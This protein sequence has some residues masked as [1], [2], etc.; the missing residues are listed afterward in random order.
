MVRKIVCFFAI[1]ALASPSFAGDLRDS[2]RKVVEEGAQQPTPASG[3]R[4]LWPGIALLAGGAAVALYG[5]S[6]T[7]GAE[8]TF[9]SD[10]FGTRGNIGIEEK[11]ST[12]VGLAGVGVSALGAVLIALGARSASP[13]ITVGPGAIAIKGSL[14]F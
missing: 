14:K 9:N 2:L 8:V 12:G 7:T 4:Y 3:N 5:F 1:I 6:H 13:S 10:P 11:K